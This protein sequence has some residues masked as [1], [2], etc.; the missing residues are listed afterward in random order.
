MPAKFPT[1]L[2]LI[3]AD[4]RAGIDEFNGGWHRSWLEPA[5]VPVEVT[6]DGHG[7]RIPKNRWVVHERETHR[8]ASY[9]GDALIIHSALVSSCRRARQRVSQ[10]RKLGKADL[11]MKRDFPQFRLRVPIVRSEPPPAS[12]P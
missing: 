11:I 8:R 10:V 12:F 6:Q 2:D 3:E 9:F 5:E 4:L 7:I 1:E